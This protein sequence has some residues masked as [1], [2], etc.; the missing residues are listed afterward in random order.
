MPPTSP[1]TPAQFSLFHARDLV[2]TLEHTQVA[3]GLPSWLACFVHDAVQETETLCQNGAEQAAAA[4]TALLRKLVAAARAWLDAELDTGAA[5]WETGVC[6][7]TIRRALRDGRIPDRRANP[8]GRHRVRRGD[9]L[10]IAD[11]GRPPYDPTADA[12]SIAQLRRKL[13]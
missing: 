2:S 9:L 6:E 3:S 10:R 7:E 5:A 12:Q 4:R 13:P 1:R 8:T 11:G